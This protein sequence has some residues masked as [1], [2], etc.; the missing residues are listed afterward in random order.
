[1]TPTLRRLALAAPLLLAACAGHT[2]SQSTV[3]PS[4]RIPA[5][6][7]AR[8]TAM[9]NAHQDSVLHAFTRADVDFMTGMIAHHAQAIAMAHLIPDRTQNSEIHTLGGRIIN[10]QR[11]EIALMQQWLRE[12]GLPVPEADP[13]GM[14][15]P[16]M[17]EHHMLMPGMLT[18]EQMDQLT[19]AHGTTFD[20][21]FLTDMIQHHSGAISM[22]DTLFATDGAAQDETVFKLSSGVQVD[23]RTEINRMRL[24]LEALPSSGTNR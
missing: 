7:V 1:M 6:S 9:Y 15:M 12:R 22:V 24:M 13:R 10:A 8:L 3:T 23:Q 14:S 21:L 2:R 17:P 5:D 20:R 11:D 19:A 16:G 18:P 4:T